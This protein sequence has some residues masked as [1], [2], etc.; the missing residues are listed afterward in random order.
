MRGGNSGDSFFFLQ[1]HEVLRATR[2]REGWFLGC[3]EFDPS[4]VFRLA[5]LQP[6]PSGTERSD[7][8]R[9]VRNRARSD[10]LTTVRGLGIYGL[11][12]LGLGMRGHRGEGEK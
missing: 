3:S 8:K 9:G 2:A 6:P 7:V 1:A 10:R 5:V 4:P 11:V 12:V